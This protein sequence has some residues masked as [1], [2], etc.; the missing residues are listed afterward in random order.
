MFSPPLMGGEERLIM[1]QSLDK[2]LLEKLTRSLKTANETFRKNFPGD[3]G[4]RQPIHTIYGGAQLFKRGTAK[5]MG[6]LSLK[7]LNTFAPNAKDFA[8]ALHLDH[9]ELVDTVYGRMKDKLE[10][11]AVEDFRIDFEDGFGVRSNS[12]EDEVAVFAANEVAEGMKEKTLPPFIGIRIKP[13]NNEFYERSLRT[14]DLFLTELTKQT[15]GKLPHGFV[16]T[17]PKIINVE[18]VE[19]LVSALEQL[20][21]KTAF[22]KGSLQIEFMIEMPQSILDTDG[23]CI[24]PKFIEAAKGRCKAAHFGVY[25]FTASTNITADYQIMDHPS[26]DFARQMMKLSFEGTGIWLSDG[27]TNVMPVGES[28]A[29]HAAWRLSYSHIQHS[30]ETG[31]YQGWDLHPMQIPIRYATCYFFFLKGLTSS[32]D[33]LKNFIDKAAKATLTGAIFDDAATGQGLLNFFLRAQNCGAISEEDFKAIGLTKEE[34]Q[35][36]SFQKIIE[37]RTK[38]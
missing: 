6:E 29:V 36:R 14:L 11:E 28:E 19:T 32:T 5:K 35:L 21:E 30:L 16:V 25:D 3:S 37:N 24:M 22:E 9:S 13:L 8:V 7:G 23:S 15:E 2:D 17:L 20:E 26:C 27:A 33:R 31:F 12:E 10:T 38:I 4:D 34:I 18:Q 1:N